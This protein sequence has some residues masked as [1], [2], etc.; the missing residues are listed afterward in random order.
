MPIAVRDMVVHV[1]AADCCL[2]HGCVA[3]MARSYN[4]D[5]NDEIG[6]TEDQCQGLDIPPEP[7]YLFGYRANVK[8]LFGVVNFISPT[9]AQVR[10]V[11]DTDTMFCILYD[12]SK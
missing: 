3:F 12:L 7:Y 6:L 9:T 4:P 10:M 5:V 2:E 11:L 1:Y 8:R